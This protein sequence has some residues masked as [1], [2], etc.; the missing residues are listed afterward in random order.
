MNKIKKRIAYAQQDRNRLYKPTVVTGL[1]G[2]NSKTSY[3]SMN[4]DIIS[5]YR[6]TQA[7]LKDSQHKVIQFIG[8]REGEGTST[9]AREFAMLAVSQ[10][11]KSV[12]L[13]DADIQKPSQHNFFRIAPVHSLEDM[14][15]D[16]M[17]DG[18]ST[19]SA[20]YRVGNSSLSISIISR[21]SPSSLQVFDFFGDGNFRKNLHQFDLLIIDSPPATI[22]S[23]GLAISRLADGVVLV[24]EAEKTRWPVAES[25]KDKIIQNGGKII[26]I[27]L[28]K[29]QYHI[30][31]SIYRKL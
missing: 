17:R 7:L 22:S 26:G 10:F 19:E 9:I 8:S 23:D 15:K 14:M 2:F 1:E 3:L 24:L 12:L 5:L 27:A 4:D 6:S 25:I 30:P 13:L 11:K 18:S 29:R 28:N 16:I 20:C 21:H 31:E